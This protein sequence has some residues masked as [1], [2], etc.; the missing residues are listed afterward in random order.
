MGLS[1][2]QNLLLRQL[3][4]P[5]RRNQASWLNVTNVG[6]IFQHSP[7]EGTISQ[8]WVFRHDLCRRVCEPQVYYVDANA[9]V[10]LHFMLM[11]QARLSAVEF[12]AVRFLDSPFKHQFLPHLSRVF[13]TFCHCLRCN[14][15]LEIFPVIVICPVWKRLAGNVFKLSVLYIN[16]R[17]FSVSKIA[18]TDHP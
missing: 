2:D 7:H 1:A 16:T 5:L 13:C 6:S 12:Q 8:N 14:L 15:L 11:T 3:L 17:S 18:T 10:L 9:A 4:C